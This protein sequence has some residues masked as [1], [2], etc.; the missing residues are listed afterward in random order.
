M[1]NPCGDFNWSDCICTSMYVHEPTENRLLSAYRRLLQYIAGVVTLERIVRVV[2]NPALLD[3]W[4]D[5]LAVSLLPYQSVGFIWRTFIT[6][7]PIHAPTPIDDSS[8][9]QNSI[10][11]FSKPLARFMPNTLEMVATGKKVAAKMFRRCAACDCCF[12]KCDWSS[13]CRA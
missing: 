10:G 11:M 4:R 12:T 5:M 3:Q 6:E 1:F 9:S 8:T 13:C 7:Y 2:P